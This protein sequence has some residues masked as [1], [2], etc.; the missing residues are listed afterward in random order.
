MNKVLTGAKAP[1]QFDYAT[2]A[3]DIGQGLMEQLESYIKEHPGTGLIVIDTLQKVRAAG[4]GRENAYSADYREIG[5]LKRFADRHGICL[6]VVHHLRK[7]G[8]DG[9]PFN[10]ISG[11]NGIMGA[12]DTALVMTKAKRSDA[13][14]TLSVTGRDVES[15]DTVIEFDKTFYKW[16]VIGDSEQIAEQ[17]ARREYQENPIV[18]TIKKLLNQS[19]GGWSG[20]MQELMDAG[21]YLADAYLAATPRDLS[22]K[23]KALDK[24]LFDYDRIV[25]SRG[26]NGT[27]GAKHRLFYRPTVG[28]VE[29]NNQL[30]HKLSNVN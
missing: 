4:N 30:Q 20:T 18:V 22:S 13:Q 27:G 15:S 24:P 28:I 16:R 6:M 14:T 2:S 8:D 10:R 5:T 17:R 11:T 9:D 12:V 29:G 7:M 25:H 3:L 1:E 23:L 19:P 26:E 21:K